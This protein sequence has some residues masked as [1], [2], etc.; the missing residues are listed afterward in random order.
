MP[1]YKYNGLSEERVKTH[2]EVAK[3]TAQPRTEMDDGASARIQE[4]IKV[5]QEAEV[6][7]L[8]D[9]AAE[10][11]KGLD[12]LKSIGDLTFKKGEWV[13]VDPKHPLV[14]KLNTLVGHGELE[15]MSEA[16]EAQEQKRA[17]GK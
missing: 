4:Q 15:K 16:Q 2:L 6:A 12:R 11:L 5:H 13:T 3:K 14:K 17:K 10:D 1:S 9:A 8:V 7:E